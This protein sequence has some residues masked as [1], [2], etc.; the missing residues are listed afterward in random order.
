MKHGSNSR[1]GRS[2]GGG[3]RHSNPRNQ[4]F[5]SNGPEGKVRGTPQQ[6]LDKYLSMARDAVSAG[7]HITAEGFYQFAEHYYR[8]LNADQQN[9]QRAENQQAQQD[10]KGGSDS[11][12]RQDETQSDDGGNDSQE[13][14]S[15]SRGNG[16]RRNGGGRDTTDSQA[17]QDASS[18][19][20]AKS[21]SEDD[22]TDGAES[23]APET[24]AS[25]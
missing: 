25:A 24:A 6:I 12:D 1:R 4:T 11:D 18:D 15:K 13:R 3:K 21:D 17:N 8:I 5:D 20:E 9:R 22:S 10:D 2:R 7:E 23:E 19:V 16:R 14:A